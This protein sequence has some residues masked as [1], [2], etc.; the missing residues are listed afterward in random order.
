LSLPLSY[1]KDKDF[2]A[3]QGMH[4]EN[5][6]QNTDNDIVVFLFKTNWTEKTK[7]LLNKSHMKT[8]AEK[9]EVKASTTIDLQ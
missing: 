5:I 8:V 4:L 7:V 2:Y 6:W 9:P 3:S 1:K